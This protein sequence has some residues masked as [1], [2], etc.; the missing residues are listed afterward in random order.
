MYYLF[1]LFSLFMIF[2][3]LTENY[4]YASQTL[5]KLLLQCFQVIYIIK[6]NEQIFHILLLQIIVVDYCFDFHS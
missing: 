4:C 6:N 3:L 1:G 2:Y 5:N